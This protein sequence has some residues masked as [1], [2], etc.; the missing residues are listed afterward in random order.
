M[1]AASANGVVCCCITLFFFIPALGFQDKTKVA[2]NIDQHFITQYIKH[3]TQVSFVKKLQHLKIFLDISW[4][5]EN[6]TNRFLI[7]PQ[8]TMLYR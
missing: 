2:M 1:E 3:Y 5:H 8:I 7:T 4:L 6:K